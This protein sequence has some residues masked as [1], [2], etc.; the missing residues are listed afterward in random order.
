MD[1]YDASDARAIVSCEQ[2]LGSNA[3]AGMKALRRAG[4]AVQVVPELEFVP[5]R[6][7]SARMRALG[8]AFRTGAVR[9]FNSELLRQA[10]L[11]HPE[12]FLAFKGA[13]VQAATLRAL[14]KRGVRS[15]VFYPDVSFL[16]H[17]RYLPEALRE[18]DW[19]FTAKTFGV[20][21]LRDRLQISKASVLL[22][23]FDPD[24]H[25]PVSLNQFDRRR[26]EC[27]VSFIGTWSPKKEALL[28]E[29]LSH[30]PNLRLRVFGEQWNRVISPA[31]R[32]RIAG[33]EVTGVEYVRAIAASSINLA[34]LSEKR[35][36]SSSGDQIT[37]RTFHIPACGGFM[38]HERTDEL[39]RLFVEDGDVACY[40]DAN[41][42]AAKVDVHLANG[43][44]RS[45][46]ADQG[47]TKVWAQH[48]WDH[49]IAEI[50]AHHASMR[51]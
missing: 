45:E 41:E 3:Y 29:L 47:R 40:G 37:S 7:R 34:I 21:D 11:Q 42:L 35:F 12:F 15:Y 19:V 1:T 14:R 25:R 10:E 17:G 50:L 5:L 22:H 24:L 51:S 31:L 48:S 26:Y 32:A 30:R 46:I 8:R 23:G 16:A 36:G 39:L 2:W 13:F 27:D 20:H 43:R 33:H 6:W 18:Y 38:L 44:R 49:R 28:T 4:W 9:E